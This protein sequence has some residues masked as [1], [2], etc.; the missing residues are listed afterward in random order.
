MSRDSKVRPED[1]FGKL[2]MSSELDKIY[3]DKSENL[4]ERLMKRYAT[5]IQGIDYQIKRDMDFWLKHR[6]SR[7][8]SF[9]PKRYKKSILRL[10]YNDTVKKLVFYTA[11]LFCLIFLG[12]L[13]TLKLFFWYLFKI[14][15]IFI[16]IPLTYWVLAIAAVYVRIIVIT[17]IEFIL[18]ILDKL[19][20]HR[21]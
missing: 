6:P 20:G 8:L 1:E 15:L 3:L 4:V 7:W 14:W 11:L 18:A 13:P 9:L 2:D 17:L 12:F 5:D 19:I 21:F 10:I 16:L